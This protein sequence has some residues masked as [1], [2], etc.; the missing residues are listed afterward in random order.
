MDNRGGVEG[1]RLEA[2]AKNTKK[3]SD[4]KAMDCLSEDW[5]SRGQGQ[6]CSRPR[7]KDQGHR[8]KCSQ[9]IKIKG[10]QFFFSADLQTFNSSKTSSVLEP[11]TGQFSRTWGFEAKAKDFTFDAK[12][13][14][15]K[16]CPRDQGRPPGLNLWWI[17]PFLISDKMRRGWMFFPICWQF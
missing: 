17:T 1:T 6:E 10:F 3:K 16:V 9:K 7:T 13:K 11:R 12:V 4:A 15:F 14:G 2:K 5:P 8:R